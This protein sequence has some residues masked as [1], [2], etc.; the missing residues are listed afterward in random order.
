MNLLCSAPI[1][2]FWSNVIEDL[3]KK[4]SLKLVYWVGANRTENVL[5]GVFLHDVW[6]AFSLEGCVPGW[7]N[8]GDVFDIGEVSRVEYYN[9]LKI[10]DRVDYGGFSFSERDDL[11]KRQLSYW[12]FVL[13]KYDI[14][15]VLFS[16]APHL[17]YDYPLYLCAKALGIKTVMFNASSI[18]GWCYLTT[19]IGG[20]AIE[21]GNGGCQQAVLARM[22][23]EGIE[24]FLFSAH[25][26]PWYMKM[27]ARE[28]N[29]LR[30]RISSTA[31]ASTVYAFA[32]GLY[33]WVVKRKDFRASFTVSGKL[34]TF[35]FYDGIYRTKSLGVVELSQ[36]KV[37]G[38]KKKEELSNEYR[39]FARRIDP[40]EI[41]PYVYFALHYQ[42]E[43]TTTPLG[44]DAS[45]Q[46]YLV[47]ALSRALPD[48]Y[49][50]VIKE[51]PS[52]L[53]RVLY[54]EQGRS[55]G[56]WEML[57][58]LDN[59]IICDLEVPSITLV[60]MA[61]LVVTVT[62]TVGWEAMVNG[63][64]CLYFGGAWYQKFPQA[65]KGTIGNLKAQLIELLG[66]ERV[67]P[68]SPAQLVEFFG[69]CAIKCDVH[70]PM[71]NPAVRDPALA[72]EYL[73]HAID[74]LS[75]AKN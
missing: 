3:E 7:E 6:K 29:S 46:F 15:F 47:R 12:M 69:R 34:A 31:G 65:T 49:K 35:K 68:I 21:A 19:E 28:Q 56:C 18:P 60:K 10:L 23:K 64:P 38:Q 42:P 32:L 17:P 71:K 4:L 70:G 45:D 51:H 41:G 14:G 67:E 61:S 40:H 62:G 54:G 43:L 30:R 66:L 50:L 48:G 39:K 22:H 2:R 11:F 58:A 36:L 37:A 8:Q 63:K 13:K 75:A 1:D 53:A 20:E 52:Q 55:R 5:Q 25:Q 9:Y 74:V 44:G 24:P 59:V 73:T 16:N 33:R 72:A 26:N 27:Q 57:S